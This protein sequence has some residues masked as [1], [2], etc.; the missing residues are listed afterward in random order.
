MS[1]IFRSSSLWPWAL[2]SGPAKSC[3][4]F[5][6]PFWASKPWQDPQKIWYGHLYIDIE[7]WILR[8]GIV[9]SHGLQS[10]ELSPI[11]TCKARW[12]CMLAPGRIHI[13]RFPAHS[14]LGQNVLEGQGKFAFWLLCL[15]PISSWRDCRYSA[16]G[17]PVH[18][19]SAVHFLLAVVRHVFK[20]CSYILC[21]CMCLFG[22]SIVWIVYGL[23]L[24]T[25]I[26][27]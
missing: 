14:S 23:T 9:G 6:V 11:C 8:H 15:Q 21:F 17:L 27:L 20:C 19:L 7:L 18:I 3:K 26:I 25:Y 1:T 10:N 24:S 13:G 12:N 4:S 5:Y 22:I 2:N 16:S